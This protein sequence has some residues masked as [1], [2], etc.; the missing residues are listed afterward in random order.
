M[1]LAVFSGI[2]FACAVTALAAQN[3]GAA[4]ASQQQVTLIGCLQG[5]GSEA[6]PWVLAGTVLPPPPPP[7]GAAGR[8]G[9]GG[10]GGDGAAGRGGRGDGAPGRGGAGAGRGAGAPP[11]AP[12]PPDPPKVSLRLLDVNM[13]PWRD[14]RVQLDGT[15]GPA[16]AGS[17]M[18]EFHVTAARSAVGPCM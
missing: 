18:R 10:R 7:P 9:R 15:L 1:K 16:P 5:D 12:P 13:T 4:G 17:A 2:A 3:Q 8:G 14:M 6:R 11:A